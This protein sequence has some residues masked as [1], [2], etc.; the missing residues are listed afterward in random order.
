MTA[1]VPQW[2]LLPPQRC[3]H[4][5]DTNHRHDHVDDSPRATSSR[6]DVEANGGR[7]GALRSHERNRAGEN[8]S[9][10]ARERMRA[11]CRS[12]A[13]WEGRG[14]RRRS[15]HDGSQRDGGTGGQRKE[16]TRDCRGGRDSTSKKK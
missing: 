2:L 14:G 11:G 16:R 15:N 4:L 7:E 8:G 6:S 12:A 5:S 9:A 10:A 3:G 1:R 13:A